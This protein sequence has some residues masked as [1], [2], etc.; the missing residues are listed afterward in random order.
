MHLARQGEPDSVYSPCVVNLSLAVPLLLQHDDSHAV[1]GLVPPPTLAVDGGHL[2]GLNSAHV[3]VAYAR[4]P[5]VFQAFEESPA[6]GCMYPEGRN[7]ASLGAGLG[8]CFGGVNLCLRGELGASGVVGVVRPVLGRLEIR[9]RRRS[10][11]EGGRRKDL[12]AVEGRSYEAVRQIGRGG[13][14]GE[15]RVQLLGS[16]PVVEVV[17]DCTLVEEELPI[18]V[19]VGGR[20]ERPV[21][22]R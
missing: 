17:V 1:I 18:E 19:E 6:V 5:W 14:N 20:C 11:V 7:W 8:T 3:L 16:F 9:W 22:D 21:E 15:E 4:D 13:V 2:D 12:L 10:A